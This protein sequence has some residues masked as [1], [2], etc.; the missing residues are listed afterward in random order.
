MIRS[1]AEHWKQTTEQSRDRYQDLQ[2]VEQAFRTMKTTDIQMRPIRHFHE[3]QVR[4]H[5]FAGV[6]AYRVI[7]ELRQRWE[8]VLRRHPRTPCCEAGSLAEIGRDLST[9]TLAT[10]SAHGKTFFKL[11]QISPYGQKLLTLAKIP[12]LE[13]LTRPSQ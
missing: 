7:W 9:V 5:I 12:S 6:L 1:N 11:S 3:A 8:P 2:Y 10:L 13:E 4:G